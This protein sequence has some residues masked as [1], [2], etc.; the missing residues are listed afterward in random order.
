[1]QSHRVSAA[2]VAE[3]RL[4]VIARPPDGTDIVAVLRRVAEE[5]GRVR[6]VDFDERERRRLGGQPSLTAGRHPAD[7]E[8]VRLGVRVRVARPG[9]ANA[10]DAQLGDARRG[11]GDGGGVDVQRQAAAP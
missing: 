6:D 10:V 5:Q 3:G 7:G 11:H 4:E 2:P 8:L 9:H 1:M